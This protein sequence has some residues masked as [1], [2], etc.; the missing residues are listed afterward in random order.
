MARLAVVLLGLALAFGA[1]T[2]GVGFSSFLGGSG[3]DAA[4][5]IALDSQG[6]I[7]IAG[8]TGSGNGDAFVRKISADGRTVLYDVILGGSGKDVASAIAV[9]STGAAYVAGLTYSSNFPLASAYRNFN[10]GNGDAFV[11]KL[12]PSGQP[13]FSTY[14]GGP[15][16]DAATGIAVDSNNQAYVV[17]QTSSPTFPVYLAFQSSLRGEADAF[18]AKFGVSGLSLT[19]CTYLGGSD[20]DGANAVAVDASGQA[21]VAGL[22]GSA[23]FPLQNPVQGTLSGL[24]DVFVAKLTVQ[25]SSLVY[26]TFVGGSGSDA[27]YAIAVDGEGAWVTGVTGSANFPTKNAFQSSLRGGTDAFVAHLTAAGALGTFSTYLGGLGNDEG[28]AITRDSKGRCSVAGLTYSSDFPTANAVQT[29]AAGDAD[30][31][32]GRLA[33]G[34]NT[35]LFSTYYGGRNKDV[36]LGMATDSAGR[37]YVAGTTKSPDFP[38]VLALQPSYGGGDSDGFFMRLDPAD[39]LYPATLYYPRLVTD[40]G[41]GPETSEYTGFAVANLSPTNAAVRFTA[42]DTLGRPI[43]G[44]GIANPAVLQLPAKSQLAMIDTQIF[45]P[46]LTARKPIGWIIM[47][48]TVAETAGFFLAFNGRLDVLDGADVSDRT[49]A[50][51]VLP[52]VQDQG[53]TQLWV[54]NPN[55]VPVTLALELVES[56]GVTLASAVRTLGTNGLLSDTVT[57]LFPGVPM[58]MSMHVRGKTAGLGVVPFEFFG[59]AGKY[60]QGMNG[61]DVTAGAKTVYSPQY[62]VGGPWRTALSIVNYEAVRGT[63][64]AR[65]VSD[66]GAILG[67]RELELPARGKVHVTEQDFFVTPPPT[68]Y[69]QGYVEITSTVARI[70][71]SVV[72][73]DPEREA[74]STALPLVSGALTSAVFSQVASDATYFTGMAAVN[75]GEID[76]AALLEIYDRQGN[77]VRSRS[78]SIGPKRRV[79]QL[80]TEFFPDLPSLSSGYF[81]LRAPA[82]LMSFALFGTHGL[83]ALSAVPPQAGP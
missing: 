15:S 61:Q 57:A 83:T 33:P 39:S 62:V 6:N 24:T 77:P 79:S 75:P 50:E 44:S 4:H 53:F 10:S 58:D 54:A 60:V 8:Y 35:L 17:G 36:A 74:F 63:I 52:E 20:I 76:V 46:G 31:F 65:L 34:G 7:H 18:V 25:G 32:I 51:F 43:G 29:G 38:T 30:A 28:T 82:G 23:N 67:S 42:Y 47:E 21:H 66:E 48:S 73:G 68:W 22:T 13:V 37:A 80:L 26:S 16:Y 14:L 49:M 12:S 45:G 81:R 11:T 56:S 71:G 40:D 2:S 64:Q 5:A 3:E 1:D 9:D 69:V 41:A 19:F 27:A 78:L 55:S 70:G 59:K 72:F